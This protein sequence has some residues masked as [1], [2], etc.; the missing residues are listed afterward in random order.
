MH[1][2]RYMSVCWIFAVKDRKSSTAAAVGNLI[3]KSLKKKSEQEVNC[4]TSQVNENNGTIEVESSS[5]EIGRSLSRKQSK[6]SKIASL[7]RS[8]S[9]GVTKKEVTPEP[10]PEPM[11]EVEEEPHIDLPPLMLGNKN[12]NGIVL[13]LQEVS[14]LY[15]KLVYMIVIRV[16]SFDSFLLLSKG[17]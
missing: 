6:E 1:S 4:N 9:F 14:F 7:K 12:D 13:S 15:R 16:C 5:L 10:Q 8:W 11:P 3:R 17:A 2:V